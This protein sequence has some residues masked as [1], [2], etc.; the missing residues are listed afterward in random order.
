MGK[1][2]DARYAALDAQY[3]KE[4]D[5]LAGEIADLNRV[6]TGYEQG[7]KS[8]EK[9]IALI[10]K[11]QGFDELTTTMLNEFVERICVHERDKKG[12][13]NAVQAVDIYF[14]FVG[15]Y[16]PPHFREVELTPEE[17]EELRKKTGAQGKTAPSLSE[18]QSQ[19]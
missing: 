12:S 4:Q 13:R 6:I 7:R 19:R 5:E 17:Q 2:P 10:D 15:K 3:A 9:F 8:A 1:L 11:Y 16:V 14:N 18:P